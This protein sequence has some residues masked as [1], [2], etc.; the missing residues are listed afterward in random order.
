MK[1]S[2]LLLLVI[3]LG[4]TAYSQGNCDAADLQYLNENNE[5]VQGV[6]ADCGADCIFA[7]D[8][9]GC[10]TT[11]MQAQ[12][13]LSTTCIGCF[14]LQVECATSNCFF[15]C[16]FG[17]AED[18]ADCIAT[19]CLDGFN[20]CAG[21]VD[22]DGDGFTTLNDCDD[23]NADINPGAL[24][25]WYDGIDQNCDGLNDF[26]QDGDGEMAFG[27]GG[28]DCDDTNPNVTGGAA[29][30]FLD[31]DNDGFGELSSFITACSAPEGYVLNNQ[32]CDDN[33]SSVYPNAPGTGMGIDNNCNNIIDMDEDFVC[34]GDL[35]NSGNIDVSDVLLLLTDYGCSGQCL[36]DLNTDTN[37]N[38]GD[39]LILL[40]VFGSPCN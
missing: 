7:A 27:F 9:E 10:L 35:N 26:D 37:V 39:L 19:N 23:N 8:P 25:I 6:A 21:I 32:D 4:L 5:F 34:L 36:A 11:C 38:T 31:A 29:T 17:A 24:E 1:Q 28:L 12:T 2:L 30:Y 15:D 40:S 18:C 3:F 22:V 33:N 13:T 14:A 16:A 20:S